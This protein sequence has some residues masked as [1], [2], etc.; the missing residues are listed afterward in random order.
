MRYDDSDVVA[1]TEP[2]GEAYKEVVVP[3]AGHGEVEVEALYRVFK[4]VD[5]ST[6]H[7]PKSAKMRDWEV[8]CWWG[9][10]GEVGGKGIGVV[11]RGAERA[12][13]KQWVSGGCLV[14][15]GAALSQGRCEVVRSRV[16]GNRCWAD[17]AKAANN[18]ADPPS[19][20]P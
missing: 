18:R 13:S 5:G 1:A 4:T 3:C 14:C 19:P 2:Q 10:G 16:T 15:S 8:V 6:L 11:I 7:P 9:D 17:G 12:Q 20:Q